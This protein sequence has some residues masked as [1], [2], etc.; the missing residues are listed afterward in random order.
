MEQLSSSNIIVLPVPGQN[1]WLFWSVHSSWLFLKTSIIS[2]SMSSDNRDWSTIR[3]FFHL[4]NQ[5]SVHCW[6]CWNMGWWADKILFFKV[7]NNGLSSYLNSQIFTL[8]LTWNCYRLLRAQKFSRNPG[9]FKRALEK[10]DTTY[11]SRNS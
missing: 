1:E 8:D 6:V 4:N 11:P 5:T 10:P 2:I 7:L 3:F 9:E